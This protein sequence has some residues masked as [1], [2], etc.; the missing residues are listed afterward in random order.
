[1]IAYGMNLVGF[2][3]G[4]GAHGGRGAGGAGGMGGEMGGGM[5]AEG[6]FG[7]GPNPIQAGGMEDDPARDK[8]V[9]LLG[10]VANNTGTMAKKP[11]INVATANL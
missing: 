10:E 1:M 4:L 5:G 3:P 6:G 9:S 2:G 7:E 8:M 11:G